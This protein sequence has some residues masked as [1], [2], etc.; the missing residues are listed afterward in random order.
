MEYREML[1]NWATQKKPPEVTEGAREYK[2]TI[3][4]RKEDFL[5]RKLEFAASFGIF[6]IAFRTPF[7]LR[8]KG[9]SDEKITQEDMKAFAEAYGLDFD[10]DHNMTG[11]EVGRGWTSI[12]FEKK[13]EENT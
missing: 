4:E 5:R 8:Q 3:G 7:N 10:P 13:Q 1:Y 12:S 2:S 11:T 6:S 9:L